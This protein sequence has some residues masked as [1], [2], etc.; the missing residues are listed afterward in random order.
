LS[1]AEAIINYT[2]DRMAMLT[3]D[4]GK[5][6]AV[7]GTV[8]TKDTSCRR[9]DRSRLE[10]YA[11]HGRIAGQANRISCKALIAWAP[12]PRIATPFR[13]SDSLPMQSAACLTSR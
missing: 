8:T 10:E 5:N 4:S 9:R 7:E 3:G 13:D 1:N 12:T 11:E 6:V 2:A